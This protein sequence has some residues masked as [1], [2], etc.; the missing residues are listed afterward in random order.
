MKHLRSS[1]FLL[2]AL[3]LAACD[4]ASISAPDGAT[5]QN[6]QQ[7]ESQLS[8]SEVAF[9]ARGLIRD[10]NSATG[11]GVELLAGAFVVDEGGDAE[12]SLKLKTDDNGKLLLVEQGRV[13]CEAGVP[14][15]AELS[16]TAFDGVTVGAFTARVEPAADIEE[17]LIFDLAG[18]GLGPPR[19]VEVEG[20][21]VFGEG[22]CLSR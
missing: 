19:R 16:G 15:A 9:Q 20:E 2:M 17:C 22:A 14:V 18:S 6:S 10:P 7:V 21:L 3:T 8:T 5:A 1:A 13:V 12:G 4:P 11:D